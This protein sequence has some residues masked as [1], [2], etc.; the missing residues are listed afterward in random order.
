MRGH[1]FGVLA[2]LF[3]GAAAPGPCGEEGGSVGDPDAG[4]AQAVTALFELAPSEFYALPFPNDLRRTAGGIDLSGHVRPNPLIAQY[5]D[6]FATHTDGFGTNSALFVRFSGA[7]DAA[8]LPATPQASLEASAAVYLVDVDPGSPDHGERVPLRFRFEPKAGVAIGPNWLAALPYPGFPLRGATTYAL[9]VTRRLRAAGGGVAVGRAADFEAALGGGAA[10]EAVARAR[11]V[12]APLRAWLDEPGGDDVDDVACATVFTTQ[13]ATSLMGGLRQRVHAT[14]E[15]DPRD[16]VAASGTAAYVSYRGVY[17]APNFQRGEP[18][19]LAAGGDLVVDGAGLPVVQRSEALRFAVTFPTGARPAA[20]WPIVLYAHGTGGDHESFIDDGTAGRMA[21]E[22]L[23]AIGI[24]QVLHGPRDPT[25]SDPELTFF[26]FQNPLAARDNVRQ[27]AA[28]GFQLVRLVLRL[29]ID[30]HTVDPAKIYFMGHSQGGL[31]GPPFLAHEPDVEAAVLSG[32]GGLIYFSLLHKTKPQNVADIVKS[33]VRDDPLDEFNNVLA[34]VQMFIEPADPQNY[35]PL[36]VRE[37]LDG[38]GAK[39][40]YQSEGITD[41]YTPL[42][43]IEAF[44]VAMGLSP[45]GPVLR[46][47]PG[48]ALR[49]QA[50]L[51]A[52]VSGNLGGRTG[53]FLQYDASGISDGHFVVFRVAAAQRQHARFLGSL[54]QTGVATLV[55]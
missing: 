1:R 53:V 19:Y 48:F 42:P 15:P 33:L 34:L 12:L 32:A 6:T 9:V 55:P 37:P 46:P 51:T 54:A 47:V 10:G 17:D 52:P 25:G 26:N 14:P 50:T 8:S 39:H 7:I 45:V 22:G 41:H 4:G 38:V 5:L 11:A 35:A 49:G 27:G 21:A 43:N 29:A 16:V 40:V 2:A 30:G 36:L 18:P 24:D 20:G 28:D 3:L 44:G 13:D 23:A 31:T